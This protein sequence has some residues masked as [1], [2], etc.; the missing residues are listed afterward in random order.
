MAKG[1]CAQAESLFRFLV[2]WRSGRHLPKFRARSK[3]SW[4]SSL[5]KNGEEPGNPFPVH[6]RAP[7]PAPPSGRPC[8]FAPVALSALECAACGWAGCS[9][10][11]AVSSSCARATRA[12]RTA[13]PSRAQRHALRRL[14]AIVAL[15]MPSHAP[16]PLPP[17]ALLALDIAACEFAGCSLR[18]R[19]W[20]PRYA[21]VTHCSTVPQQEALRRLNTTAM[22]ERESRDRN[23]IPR[24]RGLAAPGGSVC[25][26]NRVR[27]CGVQLALLSE[28]ALAHALRVLQNALVCT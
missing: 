12:S 11:C 28:S 21:R 9:S 25:A 18:Q 2:R 20:R 23:A 13:A 27:V 26:R 8:A 22:F 14:N 3:E 16:A 15:A 10:P 6:A 4:S 7:R 5:P 19:L 1:K 24:P 17:V